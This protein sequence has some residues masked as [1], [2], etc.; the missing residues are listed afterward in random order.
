M[1]YSE[2]L[3]NLA[4]K[5]KE[6]L[7]QVI[8]GLVTENTELKEINSFMEQTNKRLEQLERNQ[9]KHIQYIR[10]DTIEIVGIPKTIS[11]EQL[12]NEVIRIYGAAGV[13]VHGV[14]P[15][16]SD[17][18]ACHRLGKKQE[19]T[20]CKFLNRKFAREGLYCGKNLK[21]VE[22][23]PGT[24]I[25]LNDSF[26]DDF[27][28]INYLIRKAKREDLIFRWKVR[29]GVNYIMIHDGDSFIEIS[30]K[31]DLLRNNLISD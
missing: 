23:Y 12:E 19:T 5:T 1:S 28:H 21:D 9:N 20:I 18:Q 13:K 17:I 24:K 29:N 7:I 16:H 25:Y 26:C 15:S 8:N 4:D 27:R 31:N 6:Q 11:Q 2:D 10:R 3:G 14:S 30:H 22:L